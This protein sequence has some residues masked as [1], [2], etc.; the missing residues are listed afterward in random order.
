MEFVPYAETARP[1]KYNHDILNAYR[2]GDC[3]S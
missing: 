2:K 1:A 3:E